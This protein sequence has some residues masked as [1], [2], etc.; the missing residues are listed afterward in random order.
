MSEIEKFCNTVEIQCLKAM[1]IVDYHA[2]DRFDWLIFGH[3]KVDPSREAISILSG[4]YKRFTLIVH[5]VVRRLKLLLRPVHR[6]E[7]V[8]YGSFELL[9]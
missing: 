4:K 3:Q 6:M 5:P 1:K 7:F 8:S 2:N 9:C